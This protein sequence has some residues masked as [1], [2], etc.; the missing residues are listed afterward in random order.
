M[1]EDVRIDHVGIATA[2]LDMASGFWELVGM[3]QV[4]EDTIVE[5]QGVKVRYM[6]TTEDADAARIELLEPTS[7]D[8][9]VGRFLARRGAGVQQVCLRVE[10]LAVTLELLR[11]N[12]VR[13]IDEE[14]RAGM[15]G[16]LIAFVH[17]SS[18]GGVLVELTQRCP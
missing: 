18:T 10:N 15:H 2:D 9:P 7:D 11:A 17:P 1:S 16:S 12:G 6:G 13:L 5:D 14:P 3:S 8:T 4:V